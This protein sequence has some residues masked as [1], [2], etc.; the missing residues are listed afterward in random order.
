MQK[1]V[2]F[3]EEEFYF[4]KLSKNIN[5]RKV[6]DYCNYAGKQRGAAQSIYKSKFNVPNEVPVGFH[7]SS[8]YDYHFITKKICKGV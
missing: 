6:R 5:Y 1:Y 4:S 2:I 8:N 7:N 3:A